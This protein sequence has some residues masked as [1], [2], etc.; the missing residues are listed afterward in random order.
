MDNKDKIIECMAQDIAYS[1]ADMAYNACGDV[2]CC[3]CLAKQLIEQGYR[4]IPDDSVVLT[5]EGYDE[6]LRQGARIDFLK[7]CIQ[8]ACKETA[9]KFARA[10]EFHSV[11]TIKD[12]REH[13]TISALGL[14]D[15][16]HE[17]FGIPYNEIAKQYEVE[18]GVEV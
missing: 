1:C 8:Q 5:R 3:G 16:L 4:K 9:E 13:F 10:V 12:G 17:E 11:A 18:R 6:F 15:I 7:D 2:T 14:K